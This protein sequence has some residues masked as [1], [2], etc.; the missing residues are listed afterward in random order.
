MAL[1]EQ[2]FWRQVLR[3]AAK[4]VGAGLAVL[5]ETEVCQFE[6]SLLVNEDVLRL[7]IAIDDVLLVQILEH[8]SNLG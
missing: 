5:G 2:Y 7:Q 6:V 8:E 3:R 1:V 4:R